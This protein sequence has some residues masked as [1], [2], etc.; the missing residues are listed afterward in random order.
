L[1]RL[2]P[3]ATGFNTWRIASEKIWL[4]DLLTTSKSQ[5]MPSTRI[6]AQ[7]NALLVPKWNYGSIIKIF[8]HPELA[9]QRRYSPPEVVRTEKA[10]VQGMPDFDLI[11]TSH[12]EKQNDTLR[13]HCRRLSR[14]TNA[15]S[16]KPITADRA[17]LVAD[18]I[19]GKL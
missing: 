12:V 6:S 17:A 16:K 14:L 11:L 2:S 15:F 19:K 18:A 4:L 5:A 7:L 8:G 13:M 1:C 3:S 9:V 10:I